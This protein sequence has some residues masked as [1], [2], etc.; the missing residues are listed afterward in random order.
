MSSETGSRLRY[1]ALFWRAHH[2]A[3]ARMRKAGCGAAIIVRV[4]DSLAETRL[5]YHTFVSTASTW[6]RSPGG[7]GCCTASA[8]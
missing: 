6:P 3:C 2:E 4:V 7:S 8:A 1:G 5:S